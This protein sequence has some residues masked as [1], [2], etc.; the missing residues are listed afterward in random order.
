MNSDI[1]ILELEPTFKDE[2]FR[3]P[4]KFGTGVI[5]AITSLTVRAQVET[6]AG[7]VGEGWGNIL[8]SDIWGYPSDVMSHEERDQAMRRVAINFCELLLESAHFGHPVDLYM[9]VKPELA[10]LASE[11]G[12]DLKVETPMPLLGALVCAS[13]ADAAI[14]YPEVFILKAVRLK[15]SGIMKSDFR[16]VSS[17]FTSVTFR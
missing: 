4:L 17:I 16:I 15:S 1:R 6:L 10:R 2:E 14:V 8:L 12:E 5:R 13:P 9:E 11:V 3:T 7:K